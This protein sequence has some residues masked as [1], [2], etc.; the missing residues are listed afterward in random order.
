MG[1]Q[2]VGG[3]GRGI[4]LFS[5]AKKGNQD[6]KVAAVRCRENHTAT[7]KASHLSKEVPKPSPP[8]RTKAWLASFRAAMPNSRRTASMSACAPPTRPR[9]PG[10]SSSPGTTRTPY[11]SPSPADRLPLPLYQSVALSRAEEHRGLDLAALLFFAAAG[12]T[13]SR[14]GPPP[15]SLR[16]AT[17]TTDGLDLTPAPGQR[18]HREGRR[19]HGRLAARL[20]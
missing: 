5:F 12:G 18:R 11:P 20:P 6:G 19:V 3:R 14:G 17:G 8:P 13:S 10:P 16:G 9:P 15:R 2:K 7:T 1:P 4:P